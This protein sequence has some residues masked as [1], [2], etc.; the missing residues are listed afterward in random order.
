[1]RITCLSLRAGNNCPEGQT[2][3]YQK[4]ARNY[5]AENRIQIGIGRQTSNN[6]QIR[7]EYQ[8]KDLTDA[9]TKKWSNPKPGR[10][11]KK[12]LPISYA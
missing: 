6:R 2:E 5:Y 10:F 11:C 4:L 8:M 1:M 3:A 7:T 12:T 9:T